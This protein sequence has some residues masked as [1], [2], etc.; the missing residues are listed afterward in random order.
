MAE[1]YAQPMG[2]TYSSKPVKG[3]MINGDK[4][5]LGSIA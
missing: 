2:A 4:E 3:T 5:I 1:R